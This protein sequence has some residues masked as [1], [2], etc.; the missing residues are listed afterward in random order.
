LDTKAGVTLTVTVGA[1]GT[2]LPL[3][4]ITAGKSMVCTR[5]LVVAE[6]H[7]AYHTES[8][9]MRAHIMPHYFEH[10]IYPITGG[11]HCMLLLDSYSAHIKKEVYEAADRWNIELVVVP[12]CMTSTMSP[13]DVGVNGPLKAMYSKKWRHERLFNN[14]NNNTTQLAY[15]DASKFAIQSYNNLSATTIRH[16]FTNSVAF[17]PDPNLTLTQL[18][19]TEDLLKEDLATLNTPPPPPPPSPP[20]SSPNYSQRRSN[21][22]VFSQRLRSSQR[23]ATN[24][25]DPTISDA[26]LARSLVEDLDDL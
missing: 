20:R 2:K 23:I 13:L 18:E 8:G 11:E 6:P 24:L 19:S 1:D 21:N 3:Y 5:K 12:A 4:F 9:W 16:S 25:S 22:F 10:I 17:P 14:N 26:I 15:G 7:M